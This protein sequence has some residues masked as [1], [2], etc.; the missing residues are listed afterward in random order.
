MAVGPKLDSYSTP[1]GMGKG[2]AS[3]VDEGEL[4]SN[5]QDLQ[6]ENAPKV[7]KIAQMCVEAD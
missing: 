2:A 4:S 6:V 1:V 5:R 3:D 7:G